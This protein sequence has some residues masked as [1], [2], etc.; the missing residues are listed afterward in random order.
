MT[1]VAKPTPLE[2]FAANMHDAHHLVLLADGLTNSRAKRMRKELRKRVGDA[3]RVPTRQQDEL[4][5][6]ESSDVYVTFKPGSRLNRAS[7]SDHRPLLRQALVAACAAT[8]TYLADKVMTRVSALTTSR[9]ASTSKLSKLKL[10]VDDWLYIEQNY[11]RRRVGLHRV[12]EA[13]VREAAS[14]SPTKFGE[15]LSLIGVEQWSR[16]L[17]T[18]RRVDK[19]ATEEFLQRVTDR[20]N[21]IVHTGDR[22]GRSRAPLSIDEVAADLIG[23]ESVVNALERVV[24]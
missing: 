16:K 21:K 10:D 2:A 8:E 3:W 9:E 18:E 4:D 1:G 23:L 24:L 22:Q 20:R 6:L 11:Q 14:T 15:L 13:R 5:C 19:G 7:F 17:D 12:I